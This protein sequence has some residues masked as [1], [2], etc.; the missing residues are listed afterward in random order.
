MDGTRGLSCLEKE[1]V[2]QETGTGCDDDDV[3]V[4]VD[5]CVGHPH[6][7]SRAGYPLGF[8]LS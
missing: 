1:L 3:G 8:P 7:V 2:V 5:Y 4:Q 6:L